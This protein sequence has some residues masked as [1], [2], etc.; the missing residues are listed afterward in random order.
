MTGAYISLY[1]RPVSLNP[2]HG[3]RTGPNGNEGGESA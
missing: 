2:G 1:D 3:T